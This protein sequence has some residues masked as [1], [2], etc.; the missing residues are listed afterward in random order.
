MIYNFSLR[1]AALVAGAVL[2]LLGLAGLVA[3]NIVRTTLAR[4][5]RSRLA[6]V[7]ILA[8]DLIW[9][10]WL[11]STMEMGEFSSF[12]RP[13]LIA[14][15][16]GFFLTI[17]FVDEFLAVRAL[18]ILALLAAEPLL[19]AA[20]FRYEASR[21]VLTVFAYT[22]IVLG[23]IWV[24]L[25]YKLRDQINWF[26]KSTGRWW[27]LNVLSFIYGVALVALAFLSY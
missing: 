9:S 18:G 16:I 11:V 21:L 2:C 10:F 20:F 5:P 19:E 3:P 14:L 17:R 13:F 8:I 7:V 26:I 15:P 22:L 25:P 6:G 1:N 12:R 24:T 23:L 4:F 27:G